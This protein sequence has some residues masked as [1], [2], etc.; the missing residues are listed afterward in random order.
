VDV[1]PRIGAYLLTGDPTW[2]ESSLSRYYDV[3]DDLVVLVPRDARSWVGR[4]LPVEECLA[5]VRAVD[6]DNKARLVEGEWVD[7]HNPLRAENAQRQEGLDQLTGMDWVLQID[8]DEILPASDRL[9]DVLAQADAMGADSVEWPMRVLY[10]RLRGKTFL[11]V[12]NRSGG[13]Q[14]E[15]P[16]PVA[17]RPGAC[18]VD[19]RRPGSGRDFIRPV[20]RGD[21]SSP[22][23]AHEPERGEHRLEISPEEAIIH[24]S[25]GRRPGSV[26]RKLKSSAHQL[27]LRRPVYFVLVWFP[28]PVTWPLLR[29]FHPLHGQLWPR[30]TREVIAEDLLV[31]P[32]R[33]SLN[34]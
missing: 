7:R 1:R 34:R 5:A 26:W 12:V 16:G 31:G 3:L 20:V 24:N 14:F 11:A 33:A 2:L 8:N 32:D 22:H 9:L 10:R 21:V 6:T 17:I 28:A 27:G 23:V 15:Y 29:N 19:C 18:L 13:P 25:W 30:L 4:P